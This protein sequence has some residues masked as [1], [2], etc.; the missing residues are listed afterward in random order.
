MINFHP[1]VSTMT[2]LLFDE[3]EAAASIINYPVVPSTLL[4]HTVKHR[5][6]LQLRQRSNGIFSKPL[7]CTSRHA[8]RDTVCPHPVGRA[9]RPELTVCYAG[10]RA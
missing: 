4:L 10:I 1:L 6:N 3:L 9:G 7:A 2:H 5:R 8:K